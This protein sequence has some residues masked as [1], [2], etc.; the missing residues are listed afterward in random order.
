MLN[1]TSIKNKQLFKAKYSNVYWTN[2]RKHEW[3]KVRLGVQ[4]CFKLQQNA[5]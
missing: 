1:V 4:R 2:D 5:F 3:E